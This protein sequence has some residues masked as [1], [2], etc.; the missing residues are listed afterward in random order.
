MFKTPNLRHLVLEH[1][2]VAPEQYPIL[3]SGLSELTHLDLSNA[4]NIGNFEFADSIPNL[5]SLCLYNVTIMDDPH[6]F[7]ANVTQ[8]KKL[9]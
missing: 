7:V 9:R 1:V 6:T 5:V 3:L 2:K 4:S 8:L